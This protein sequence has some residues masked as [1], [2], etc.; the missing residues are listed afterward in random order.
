MHAQSGNHTHGMDVFFDFMESCLNSIDYFN[1][2]PETYIT[3]YSKTLK[4]QIKNEYEKVLGME[5]KKDI[6]CLNKDMADM[7]KQ[8]DTFESE[9][10]RVY[11]IAL[12]HHAYKFRSE[13]S[14]KLGEFLRFS[15]TELKMLHQNYVSNEQWFLF[16]NR[17]ME[18]R[19]KKL[20]LDILNELQ[21]VKKFAFMNKYYIFK[22]L[23]R[24]END[25]L[26]RF[27]AL[28][29]LNEMFNEKILNFL[30]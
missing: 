11:K 20:E 13:M 18:E 1:Q 29:Y 28:I 14:H 6:N 24:V 7:I 17:F 2:S 4:S 10:L 15:R 21:M 22:E 12:N 19:R 8:I 5:I 23:K 26:T 3:N 27:G 30:Q 9:C 16:E 25:T